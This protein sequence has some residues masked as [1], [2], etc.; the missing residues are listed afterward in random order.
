MALP[1]LSAIGI[2][3]YR[4]VRSLFMN[5][6][7]LNV[8]VGKNGTGKTNLYR[9][10]E[11]L[12]QAARGRVTRA[13]A[14]EGGVESV[15]WAGE[16]RVREK[17]QIRLRATLGDL[18]YKITIGLPQ[19]TEAALPL[20]S[21][22]KEEEL[23]L[24]AGRRN[25]PL[26]QRKGPSIFLRAKD[27]ERLTYD[28][29]VLSSETA[30]YHIR[31]GAR[32]PELDMVRHALSDWRF[33]HGFRSDSSSPLRRPSLNV[34]TPT[35]S[36]NGHDLAAVFATLTHIKADAHD[37][38][39][40]VEDAFPGTR[41]LVE[42]DGTDC[43]FSLKTEDFRRAFPAHELSEGTLQYLALLG[44]LL[45]YRLPAF[46]ALNE[47]ESS[48]HPD[49]LEPLAKVIAKASER[50]QIWIVTHSQILADHLETYAGATPR[51]IHREDGA[52]AIEGLKITGE[53]C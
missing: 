10:L 37:L 15:M 38:Y 6:G 40:A 17:P 25:V 23:L 16:R 3:N 47:P 32:F 44:G 29:E 20:E 1:P 45:S 22:V 13:I 33:F 11:L 24:N 9:A 34:T 28:N 46:V 14:E 8:F 31:D 35:L 42:A 36:S 50:T 19:A 21:M 41:L 7:A 39:E 27:G 30:L 5:I 12:Q 51:Q 26:M 2:D 4:S 53:F 18:T 52:T 49:L 48:L 43:R